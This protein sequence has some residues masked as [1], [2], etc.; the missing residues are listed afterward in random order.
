MTIPRHLAPTV[1]PSASPAG[2]FIRTGL[3]IMLEIRLPR[4]VSDNTGCFADRPFPAGGNVI[5]FGGFDVYVATVAPP[6]YPHEILR[7]A[8]PPPG[9]GASLT[10]AS[11]CVMQEVMATGD[12]AGDKSTRVRGP[13]LERTARDAGASGSGPKAPAPPSR[14]DEVRAKL[15]SPLTAGADPTTIEKDLEAHRQL[16]LRQAEELA[17]A[18]RQLEITRREYDR[19]HG[20]TPGGDNPSRAGQIRRR[21]GGLGARSL[22]TAQNRQ[23]RLRSDPSTTPPTRTC[24]RRKPPQKS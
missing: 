12:D 17:A 19:A 3:T 10:T 7:C 6:R 18:K 8:S 9:A 4:L 1:G 20:F 2:V 23:L 21:G 15:S 16:L 11:P 22:G 13:E 5:S 24:A 14:L